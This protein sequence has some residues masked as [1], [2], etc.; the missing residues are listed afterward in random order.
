MWFFGTDAETRN[1]PADQADR[2]AEGQVLSRVRA[3]RRVVIDALPDCASE[4]C[5]LT[6]MGVIPGATVRVV[7]NLFGPII[8]EARGARVCVGQALAARVHVREVADL[9]RLS[10]NSGSGRG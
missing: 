5:R 4:S 6:A 10:R 2:S 7:Q 1:E 9:G 8:L 3:G